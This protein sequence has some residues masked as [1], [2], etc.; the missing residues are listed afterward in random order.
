MKLTCT[1]LIPN[2][3]GKE[4]LSECLP[5]IMDAVKRRG[6]RDEIIVIDN[7]S[8]DDSTA[9]LRSEYPQVKT[10]SL[11]ENRAIFAVNDGARAAQNEIMVLLNNDM[12]VEP[13]FL[14]PMLEHFADEAVFAVTG[15]VYQWNKSTIQGCR[16][17]AVFSRGFFWYVNDLAAPDSQ[18]LTLHALG[19][20]SAYH[21]TKFLELCGFDTLFSPF[22]HEDLDISYRAYK[23]GWRIVYEPRSVMY[24]RGAATAGKLYSRGELDIFLQKNLFLFIWKNIHDPALWAQHWCLLVPRLILSAVRGDLSHAFGFFG[25]VRQFRPAMRRR[26]EARVEARISDREVLRLLK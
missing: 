8:T 24:H 12:I 1:I 3:N 21:K 20:Q 25:A 14:D 4:M 13:D 2:Y 10:L 22:Y 15:K 11:T 6:D 17:R 26:A 23:R 18:G 16:R 9:F 5:S 19:G 7:A